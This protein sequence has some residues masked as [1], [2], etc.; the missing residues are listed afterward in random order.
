MPLPPAGSIVV[1]KVNANDDYYEDILDC[2]D[3]NAVSTTGNQTISGTKTF[4]STIAGSITGNAGTV[5][6]GVYTT[7]DQTISGTKTFSSTI[8]GSITGN[9]GTVTSGV[10]TDRTISAGDGLTGGGSLGSNVS[11]AVDATVV[12]TSGTQTI[13]GTKTFTAAVTCTNAVYSPVFGTSDASACNLRTNN[14]TR[15]YLDTAGGLNQDGTNGGNLIFNKAAG[16]RIIHS[17]DTGYIDY[18]GG[19]SPNIAN[20]AYV[21]AVGNN[22]GGTG[23]GG[24]LLLNAGNVGNGNIVLYAPN[25][26]GNIHFRA[27]SS[28]NRWSITPS[29]YLLQDSTNTG[30]IWFSNANGSIFNTRDGSTS[31]TRLTLGAGNGNSTS[32]TSI[33]QLQSVAGYGGNIRLT[34]G[35][36]GTIIAANQSDL[37]MW[38]IEQDG[39]LAQ[40]ATRGGNI[41]LSKFNSALY[42]TCASG[43]LY[44][45][46]SSNTQWG[47]V[48]NGQVRWWIGATGTLSQDG[49]NG[50]DFNLA[51]ETASRVAYLD[52]SKN[53]KSS[54][55]TSTELGYLSGVSSAIQTQ[56]N[57]KVS[58]TADQTISGNKVFANT[59][60]VQ[61]NLNVS[62]TLNHLNTEELLIEDHTLTLN[63]TWSGAPTEDATIAVERGSSAD[64]WIVWSEGSDQW[65][66]G[67]SGA[68]QKILL[69]SDIASKLDTLG[70]LDLNTRT[71]NG[72]ST[73]GSTLFM[74]TATATYPGLI[75]TSTQYIAGDKYFNGLVAISGSNLQLLDSRNIVLGTSTGTQIGTSSSQKLGF[76][77]ATPIARPAGFT[78]T[79]AGTNTNFDCDNISADELA[80]VV[81][82]LIQRLKNLGLEG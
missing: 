61:G 14:A 43:Y 62:G 53:L 6:N 41:L 39:D 17:L 2:L 4:A 75:S 79:N 57:D 9:A 82:T 31:S 71:A 32:Y 49:T 45:G 55:V 47:L 60:T 12:R 38:V 26:S 19:S 70:T 15:W 67:I 78:I 54:S 28:N 58:L 48:T 18:C 76:W 72:A 16:S 44:T 20:G 52:A 46:T 59:L 66:A 1:T 24:Y 13:S 21:E 27:G 37:P 25:A 8:V 81:A 73:S 23:L 29:G 68:M 69:T 11:L 3:I 51:K 33:I 34:T 30:G 10:Y 36:G 5:T 42:Y 40:D 35:V 56:L 74:Q 63:S 50:G 65:Q 7:G 22:N 64:A 80:D 77:G